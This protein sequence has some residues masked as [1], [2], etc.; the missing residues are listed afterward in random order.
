FQ[1]KPVM[2]RYK[3][4]IDPDRTPQFGLI[5]EEV[6]K[7]NPNLVVRDKEGKPYSVHYDQVNAMLLNEFLRQHQRVE[8]QLGTI[9]K[10]KSI[11]EEQATTIMQ[12]R[13]DFEVTK[14]QQQNE[15]QILTAQLKDQAAQIQKVRAEIELSKSAPA[16]VAMP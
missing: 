2:F 4:Q 16:T 13:R 9:R 10:L 3:E 5:A 6:G 8:N 1:L 7:V 12:D 15:I 11:V 14:M